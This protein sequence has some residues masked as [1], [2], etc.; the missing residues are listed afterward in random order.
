[1]RCIDGTFFAPYSPQRKFRVPEA[2][3]ELLTVMKIGAD[4]EGH[5][6]ITAIY[7]HVW[8]IK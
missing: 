1:M 2:C 8:E 6:K 4:T 7:Y 5:P 3:L